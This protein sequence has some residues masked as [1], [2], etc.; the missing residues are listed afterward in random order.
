MNNLTLH[1]KVKNQ[2][3]IPMLIVLLVMMTLACVGSE[4]VNRAAASSG[5]TGAATATSAAQEFHLQLTLTAQ[6]SASAVITPAP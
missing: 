5:L 3:L 4:E 1:N 6:E 2:A